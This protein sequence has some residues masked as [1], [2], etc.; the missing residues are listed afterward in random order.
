MHRGPRPLPPLTAIDYLPVGIGVRTNI[1]S[2][3][4]GDWQEAATDGRGARSLVPRP[5]KTTRPV[6]PGGEIYSSTERRLRQ[7]TQRSSSPATPAAILFT[8]SPCT[9]SGCSATVRFEP[10]I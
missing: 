7:R 6:R 2:G 10:P 3:N 1:V 4:W 8:D 9:E 5:K